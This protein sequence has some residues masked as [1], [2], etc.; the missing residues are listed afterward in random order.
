[1]F[2]RKKKETALEKSQREDAEYQKQL[3][4]L[5]R[6][7]V[8]LILMLMSTLQ[9][10]FLVAS[11]HETLCL[12]QQCCF[13]WDASASSVASFGMPLP[14][15]LLHLGPGVRNPIVHE[16]DKFS[17]YHHHHQDYH[18]CHHHH[19][20]HYHHHHNHYCTTT[21]AATTTIT[22]TTTAPPPPPLPPPPPPPPPP[23]HQHHHHHHP[24]PHIPP[25][26]QHTD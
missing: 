17:H 23:P 13:I 25:Y 11:T 20:H 19:R 2:R 3:D 16:F 6:N 24:P 22:T 4:E 9:C 7:Q 5:R 1:M 21:A 12:C 15:A 8:M 26:P 18:C 14:A 10:F